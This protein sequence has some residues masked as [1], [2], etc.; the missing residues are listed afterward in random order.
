MSSPLCHFEFIAADPQKCKAF[1]EAV[2]G[3]TFDEQSVPG[4][5][6]I[7]TGQDPTGGIMPKPKESPG[8]CM[9]VYF[10][11]EDI[12]AT[13]AKVAEQGGRVLSEKIELPYNIGYLA[14]FVDPEGNVIGLM[15]PPSSS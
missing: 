2:F 1:Y 15:Q 14:L 13:L 12:D 7:H 6:I 5:T 4:Y 8:P 9:N 10:R 11:V 3:W